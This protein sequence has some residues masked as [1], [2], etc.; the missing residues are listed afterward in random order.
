MGWTL[1]VPSCMECYPKRSIES[2]WGCEESPAIC[3]GALP[4]CVACSILPGCVRVE[5]CAFTTV[6][7]YLRMVLETA[8]AGDLLGGFVP[9]HLRSR[10]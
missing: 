3:T 1:V 7:V 6:L 5:A 9:S 4:V 10:A 8:L 2:R